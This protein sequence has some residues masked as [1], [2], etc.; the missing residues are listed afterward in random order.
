M[1]NRRLYFDGYRVFSKSHS[2]K[3]YHSKR[4]QV[5]VTIDY[6]TEIKDLIDLCLKLPPKCKSI[7][8]LQKY[9]ITTFAIL[10]TA[11]VQGAS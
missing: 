2:R 1:P 11:E 8:P 5:R 10:S 4:N 7:R 6:C 9:G 3:T